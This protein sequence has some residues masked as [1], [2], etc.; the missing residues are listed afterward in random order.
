MKFLISES[1]EYCLCYILGKSTSGL[2]MAKALKAINSRSP[3]L[4]HPCPYSEKVLVVKN[5]KV[6]RLFNGVI[7]KSVP[8]GFYRAWIRFYTKTNTTIA[9]V[10]WLLRFEAKK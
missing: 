6:T 8:N 7:P 1:S 3:R 10:D 4:L 9:K 2:F 5:Q